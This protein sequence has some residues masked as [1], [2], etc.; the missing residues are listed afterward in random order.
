MSAKTVGAG[1]EGR[2]AALG[3]HERNGPYLLFTLAL[4]VLAIGVLAFEVLVAADPRT[5]EILRYADHAVCVLFFAD[6]LVSLY[7]AP[8]KGRYLLKWGWLDLLSSV[9]TFEAFRL[10][11]AARVF[12]ILRVLRAIRS[13]KILAEF[14]LLRRA[15]GTFLAATLISFLLVVVSSVSI[16]HVETDPNSNIK[17][18]EDAV[19]WAMTTITTVGYGDRVPVTSEGRFIG[20]VLMFAGVGLFATFSGFVAAWFLRPAEKKQ[21]VGLEELRDE[22]AE[23][24]RAIEAKEPRSG[25]R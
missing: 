7:N 13:A 12:R 4:S 2:P 25:N 24:R 8:E 18:A 17:T 16:L 9:P 22:M 15:Q 14:I 23:L 1:E 20:G 19:W 21:V 10:G 3:L 5:K 11:R 6:F